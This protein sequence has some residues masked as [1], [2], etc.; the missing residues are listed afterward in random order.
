VF[1]WTDAKHP[2]EIA[3]FD[4]GPVD[5]TRMMSGG[6]WST[7]WYNGVIVGS[8]ISRGLDIF[9]LKPSGFLSQNE[10]DAAK[11]VRFDYL[12]IQ[13]QPKL[14]WPA[15]FALARAYLDQLERS[16]GLEEGKIAA[17]RKALDGAEKASGV[18]R[19][20]ALTQL[21][22]EVDADAAGAG[23]AGKVRTLAGAVK[24]LA[25]VTS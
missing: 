9:E 11:T 21:A 14:V 18:E 1:D 6:Y 13:G 20:E 7:Y 22:T 15:S 19:Q 12:N 24:E 23:D 2:T 25:S 8:E 5:S 17:V 4:R 16:K 10:I 3:F